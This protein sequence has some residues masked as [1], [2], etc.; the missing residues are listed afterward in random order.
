MSKY[1]ET[2]KLKNGVMTEL[3]EYSRVFNIEPTY[4][5]LNLGNQTVCSSTWSVEKEISYAKITFRLRMSDK[6][7]ERGKEACKHLKYECESLHTH[8]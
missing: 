3:L 8:R 6:I 7:I 4:I 2:E 1:G 5:S